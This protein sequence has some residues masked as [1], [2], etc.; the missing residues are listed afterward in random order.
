MTVHHRLRSS[1]AIPG[2]ALLL[3]GCVSA[4]QAALYAD[5]KAGFSTVSA[6]TSS[7]TKGKQS[8]W[9]QSQD[10]ARE[11][12]RSVHAQIHRKTISADTAVQVA[13]LNNRGLQA[14]YAELGLSA[15]D[16]WQQTMLENPTVSIGILGV[17]APGLGLFRAIEGMI[18][19][20]LLSLATQK[21]RVAMADTRFRQAQVT[22]VTETLSLAHETRR[23]WIAAVSAFEQVGYLKK[24]QLSADASSE[25]A[26]RL[27]DTGAIPKAAQAREQAFYAELTGQ[28]AEAQLSARLAKEQLTRLMGVWGTEIEYFVPDRLPAL[29]AKPL[30]KDRIEADALKQRVD[31]KAAK[32]NLEAV[33]QSYGLTEATR[34]VTDL[35]LIVGFEA[36]RESETEY[37]LHHGKLEESTS[38]STVVTPQFELEFA[39][40]IFDSG[41]ARMR[42]AELAY[43][44][45]ANQLA[46]RAINIRSEARSAYT[47]Y[48]STYDIALH[49]RNAVV[50]LRSKIEEES[51]LTYNGMITNTF[52]L[53]ADS[54]AKM[55]AILMASNAKR[56][57]WL[58][59]ADLTA[60]IIGGGSPS[61]ETTSTPAA[62]ADSGGA[63]H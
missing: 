47:A 8:V 56:E 48:R 25:L 42:K 4:E 53:L 44:Q 20:N 55:G 7:L 10:D 34:Y 21:R 35:E 26:K 60:A 63:G 36:E 2:I 5:P 15:A 50:P 14:A 11:N 37:E 40:P 45:A 51:L 23:A 57:F 6:T 29:P 38:K 32:L 3:A 13:L 19:N 41:K 46:E 58:A 61:G 49:Y 54:R 27:G 1:I 24:A 22:A 43:M 17:N 18:A 62:L 39:I 28:L 9:I 52:E 31:L 12:A 30:I 33:A 59:E 16:A